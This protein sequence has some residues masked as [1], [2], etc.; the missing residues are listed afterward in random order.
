MTPHE[1]PLMPAKPRPIDRRQFLRGAGVALALPLLESHGLPAPSPLPGIVP[2]GE[3]PRRMLFIASG[4]GFHAPYFFPGKDG[5]GATDS[6]YLTRLREFRDDLTVFSGLS[7]PGV[8]GGH[9]S[10][11]SFLTAAPHPNANSFKNSI[12]LDQLAAEKIGGATRFSSLVLSTGG[13]SLSWS[14]GGVRIPA[15]SRASRIYQKL[16][17]EGSARERELQVERLRD[18]RSILDVVLGQTRSL[19]GQVGRQDRDTLG[20]YTQS[21][22]E[23]EKRLVLDEEWTRRPR[24]RVELREPRDVTDRADFVSKTDLLIDLVH[25][26]LKT[27]STRL[28]T[29][30]INSMNRVPPIKG[31]ST[32]WHNL[33]HHGKDPDKIEQLKLIEEEKIRLFHGLLGKL[34]GSR[35]GQGTLLDHTQVLLGS[36]LGNASSHDTRNLPVILAGGGYRHG[37]HL[38]FD[39]EK[40][41]PLCNLYV[42]MLQKMGLE[43]DAFASSTGTL[44]GLS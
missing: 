20:E 17:L 44:T 8:D 18:G 3:P 22:R 34:K 16:F 27:D 41:T 36:N 9:A 19:E 42:S 12:S 5:E 28:V 33:S 25:L 2:D 10:E 26:A 6:P 21:I 43:V 4:L 38:A 23:L 35:E 39:G 32:D 11:V 37:R 29:L 30:F 31:I 7:H 14:R 13:M 1:K 40:N 15:E 24:P